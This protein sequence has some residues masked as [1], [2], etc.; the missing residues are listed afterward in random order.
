MEDS[1]HSIADVLR[2]N[3]AFSSL[4]APSLNAI[5][6]VSRDME[7]APGK[8]FVQEGA[9]DHDLYVLVSGSASAI[10]DPGTGEPVV[11]NAIPAG[12]CIGELAF[13][14]GGS[15]MASVRA[16]SVCR[17]IVV[18]AETVHALADA[19]AVVGELK[20]A[21]AGVAVRRARSMSNAILASMRQ[22]V[23]AKT[24]QNQ[25]GQFLVF[26][27]S[28]LLISSMLFYHVSQGHVE[29]IYDP[30]FSWKTVFLFAVPCLIII[31][32]MK[33]PPADLGLTTVGLRRSL[34]ESLIVCGVITVPVAVYFLG[35]HTGPLN[36]EMGVT[37]DALFV[38]QYLIN[39]V[40]QE[41]G[42]RGLI[43]GLFQRFLDDR[44]GHRSVFLTS[45]IFA[46]LH[47]TFG[48]DAVVVTFFASFLFGYIYL[49][50]KNLLGVIVIH[51]WLGMLAAMVV[52]F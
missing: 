10:R 32:V 15:R 24:L 11:L 52:A 14:D 12:D 6:A 36:D 44:T 34:I 47:L 1:R 17:V 20:G 46:S 45:T 49:R 28:I 25:F 51:Y 33:I 21:L 22:Q 2:A 16:E 31:R 23:A 3:P 48:L 18:P 43:Q 7:V 41:I 38:L 37:V 27:I 8:V 39:V 42:S 26:T 13:I 5:A 9:E 4:S 40:L 19:P 35:F 29:N 30:A 50:Q